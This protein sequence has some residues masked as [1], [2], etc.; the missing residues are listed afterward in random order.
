[1]KAV[2]KGDRSRAIDVLSA[3]FDT[4][5][6]VNWVIPQDKKRKQRLHALMN[7]A[8]DVTMRQHEA[9]IH[10]EAPAVALCHFPYKKHFSLADVWSD[11][12]FAFHVTGVSGA[13]KAAKRE[14]LIKAQHPKAPFMYLWMLG[15]SPSHQGKGAGS[16]LLKKILVRCDDENLPAYLET[17]VE[18][19][20]PLYQRH[21]FVIYHELKMNDLQIRFMKREPLV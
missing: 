19:N 17:S 6:S 16:S 4:N 10:N 12:R 14:A 7:Y 13:I 1:M 18:R 9:Y 5:P 2:T 21:G 15:V 11:V 3:A 8:L 20:L